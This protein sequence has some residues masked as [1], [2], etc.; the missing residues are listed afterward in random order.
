MPDQ[1]VESV[2][3]F[4]DTDFCHQVWPQLRHFHLFSENQPTFITQS[5]QIKYLLLMTDKCNHNSWKKNR[6]KMV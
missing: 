5:N 3:S 1:M 4:P 2:T 6:R